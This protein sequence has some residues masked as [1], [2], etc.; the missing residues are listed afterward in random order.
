MISLHTTKTPPTKQTNTTIQTTFSGTFNANR[1]RR[2]RGGLR[3]KKSDGGL[4]GGVV[5]DRIVYMCLWNRGFGFCGAG[6]VCWYGF[7]GVGGVDGEEGGGERERRGVEWGERVEKERWEM[8]KGEFR[9]RRRGSKNAGDDGVQ[10]S[11][12]PWGFKNG[13]IAGSERGGPLSFSDASVICCQS[14]LLQT[15]P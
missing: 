4:G 1:G 2:R 11:P 5:A 9:E 10:M 6:R 3:G 8:G 15:A 7:G 12:A 14:C 13:Y